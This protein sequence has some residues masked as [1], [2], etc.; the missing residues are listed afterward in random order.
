MGCQMKK[1]LL[2][3]S[4][5]AKASQR[6]FPLRRQQFGNHLGI[7]LGKMKIILG[8]IFSCSGIRQIFRLQ[9]LGLQE[10]FQAQPVQVGCI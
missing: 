2:Q 4:D 3:C 7:F 9:L 8:S 10:A 5:E 6:R 1:R